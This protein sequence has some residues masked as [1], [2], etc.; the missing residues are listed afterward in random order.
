ML[1]AF[2]LHTKIRLMNIV[3]HYILFIIN[4]LRD[5]RTMINCFWFLINVCYN[6]LGWNEMNFNKLHKVRTDFINKFKDNDHV[7]CDG[8]NQILISSPH[9]VSQVRLG[10]F[11]FSEIGSLSTALYLFNN[12][13]CSL[14]AKTKNNNDDA[15]FDEVSKYKS[16]VENFIKNNNI[17]YLIDIHGLSSKRDCDINLGTRLGKTSKQ[18]NHCYQIYITC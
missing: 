4:N 15:N 14:I 3:R 5:K 7:V 9:G 11:K 10:K 16:S 18:M 13:K 1:C 17:K 8:E 6:N 2:L 12:T